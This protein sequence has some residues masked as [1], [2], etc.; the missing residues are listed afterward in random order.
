VTQ[1]SDNESFKGRLRETIRLSWLAVRL[2]WRASPRVVTGILLLITLQ[3]LFAPLELVLARAVIDSAAYNLGLAEE[4]GSVIGSVP[5]WIW[6]SLTATVLAAGQLIQPFSST[7][8]SLAGDRLTGYVTGELVAATNRWRGLARFEDPTFADD[9]ERARTH[10]ARGGLDLMVYGARAVLELFTVAALALVLLGL[11]PLVP[12]LLILASLTSMAR[13][14]EFEDRTGSHL[15]T[16]TPEARRMEYA[17]DALITPEPAK[18][19]RLYGLNPFFRGRYDDT[20]GRTFGELSRLRRRMTVPTVLAGLLAATAAG[21]VYLYLVWSVASGRGTVGELVLYG[22]AATMLQSNLLNLG[23]EVGFLPRVLRFLPSLFRVLDAPPDLLVS[24]CPRQVPQPV[25]GGITFENVSF[26]YPDR[27]EVLREVSFR[28]EPGE[29]VA[30]V[31]HNGAGKTTVVKLLL[32][33][34]DPTGGRILLDGVD[35][36]EYDPD[37]ARRQM[38]VIFQDFIRYELT[39]AENIGLGR[40]EALEDRELL[41]SA[42]EKSGAKEMIESLP[43]GLDTQLGREL[44]ERDLSGGEWQKLALARAFVRDSQLLVLDEPTASLDVQ[45]EYEIYKRFQELTRGRMTLLIS[46]RFSTVRMADRIL[47]LSHGRIEEEGS[48]EEL[49]AT[50]GEYARLYRLQASRYLDEIG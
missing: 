34:Y 35:L 24:E 23:F 36:R 11:H 21:G 40:V 10:A 38:G 31:G 48:H 46:H 12:I 14:W 43:K 7:F 29:S 42:A 41:M 30:L 22:G 49:M 44:G 47:Y 27:D 13:R 45:T 5:L 26:S 8:Q 3:A 19:V 33:L 6:I 32:R 2:A 18:D 15:Y 28:I 20:F 16:Q 25:R 1:L 50:N 17:R 9:L 39:A 37:E 4:P